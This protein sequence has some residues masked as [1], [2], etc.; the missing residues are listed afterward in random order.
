M[1]T[2]DERLAIGV[3]HEQHVTQEL[4]KHGW[5]VTVWGQGIMPAEIRNAISASAPRFRHFPDLIAA[6]DGEL[7]AVDA[8]TNLHG[9]NR[10][11]VNRDCVF[12]GLGFHAN[13]GIPVNYVFGNMRVI[14]PGEI[15]THGFLKVSGAYYL[16]HDRFTHDFD[17][18]FGDAGAPGWAA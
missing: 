13:Y 6:R 4:E 11:A 14:L 9:G 8:K 10:Y 18:V 17:A 3:E 7:L 12:F 5:T 1:T 16:V 2:F 15:M